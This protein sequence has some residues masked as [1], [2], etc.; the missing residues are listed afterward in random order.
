V[1]A[2]SMPHPTA[3]WSDSEPEIG[4]KLGTWGKLLP[5]WYLLPSEDGGLY[6]YGPAA[7]RNGLALPKGCFLDAE[8]FLAATR[9]EDRQQN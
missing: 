3:P 2:M 5:G 1:I 8:G 6:A 9:A 7:G 4:H